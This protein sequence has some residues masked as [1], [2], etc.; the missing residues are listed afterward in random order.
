MGNSKGM[1]Q[2]IDPL[3]EDCRDS[4]TR[5]DTSVVNVHFVEKEDQL[6][7]VYSDKTVLVFSLSSMRIM[8]TFKDLETHHPYDTFKTSLY[9][10]EK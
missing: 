3:T 4:H 6:V 1:V 2:I 5:K 9:H 10:V 8:Q 7:A